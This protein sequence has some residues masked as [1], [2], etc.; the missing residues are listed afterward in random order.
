M[1]LALIIA[2][3][4]TYL[5]V[6][7]VIKLA[8]RFNLIDNPKVRIH[9]AHTHKGCI[10]RAGGLSLL[11]GIIIP[12]LIFLPVNKALIG[13]IIG[14]ILNVALGLWDDWKD[15]SPY[16]RF[17]ANILVAAI[18]VGSG[19]GIPFITNPLGGIS[20]FNNPLFL[21]GNFAISISQVLAVIWIVWV[22]NM[23]NWSKGVDG[24]MPGI[25][26]ISSF[27]IGILSLRFPITEEATFIS[28]TLS[29][30][31][32]GSAL[33]FLLYN[34]Y[35]AK[36]FPGYGATAIYL[37]LSVVSMLSG[38]KLATAILV[39]G[40]PLADGAYTIARRI[41][42]GKSPFWHDRKHLHHLLL[43]KGLNQ[44]KIAL[45]YW[46][47]SAILG[48]LSLVLTSKGKLFAIIMVVILVGGALYFLN[49]S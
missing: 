20:N 37:I 24:Q 31:V 3:A 36:I 26:A 35:P 30:I 27:V 12:I 39:M 46:T 34:F 49:F 6:P 45:F 42:E 18:V 25:V 8:T 32:T 10:P 16:F 33:G 47:I 40:V 2:F 17:S 29:F 28:A 41:Y 48:T 9:P 5:T 11:L 14:A 38:A 1:L 15:L 43:S 4:I 13:I 23:L 21:I 44:R 22:M 7:L 19:I